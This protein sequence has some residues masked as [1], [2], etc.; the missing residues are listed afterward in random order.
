M[1]RHRTGG[2]GGEYTQLLGGEACLWG[3]TQAAPYNVSEASRH[4]W[5]GGLAVA[6]RLWSAR[7]VV[8]WRRAAPR[9]EAQMG[10][11]EQRVLRPHAVKGDDAAANSDV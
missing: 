10:R 2:G 5:P 1:L 9:L 3:D 7:N 8:D 4:L 6:E 11:L